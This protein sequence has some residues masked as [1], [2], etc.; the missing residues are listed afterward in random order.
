MADVV[1]LT[2]GDTV[3]PGV[4]LTTFGGNETTVCSNLT[5]IFHDATF[6]HSVTRTEILASFGLAVATI[7]VF[8]LILYFCVQV[9]TKEWSYWDM[10]RDERWRP[11]LALFQFFLWTIIIS[12]SY[13]FIEFLRLRA[14]VVTFPGTPPL[15]LLILMG[16]SVAVPIASNKISPII[17]LNEKPEPRPETLPR[18]KTIF[19][20]NGK[21]TLSRLQM[22][23]W[24]GIAAVVYIFLLVNTTLASAK[25]VS[26]LALPDIDVTLVVLMGLSQ[27]AYLGGKL[28]LQHSGSNTAGADGSADFSSVA[29]TEIQPNNGKAGQE[30]SIFGKGF[31]T[32]K[33]VVWF[34]NEKISA[35]AITNWTDARIDMTI[36]ASPPTGTFSQGRYE[37]KVASGGNL[38]SPV[39]FIVYS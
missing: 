20:E 26:A 13:L 21:L 34:N 29:I 19:L 1:N 35:G 37:V 24:T 39:L 17:L 28:V 12:F 33:D 8:L 16:I 5:A 4:N 27:G 30:I 23:L 22:F 36:P 31:G 2:C 11:S 7:V 32:T 38:S 18:M 3:F 25:D 6:V 9:V 14:G 10:I 15:N